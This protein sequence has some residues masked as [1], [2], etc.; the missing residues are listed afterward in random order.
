MLL[1]VI[2]DAVVPVKG[3]RG[4]LAAAALVSMATGGRPC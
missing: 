4:G 2:V 3:P 1:E